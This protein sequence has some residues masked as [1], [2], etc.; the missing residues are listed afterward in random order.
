MNKLLITASLVATSLLST[1]N[2]QAK[3][4]TEQNVGFTTGAITG[5][6]VGGPIG[7]FVGAVAGVLLG[8]QVEKA[9][10]LETTEQQLELSMADKAQLQKE[11]SFSQSHL[12][13]E[14]ARLDEESQETAAWIT[15][16]LRLNLLFATNSAELSEL[17]QNSLASVASLLQRFPALKLRLDAHADSRGEENF[18][19]TLSEKRAS[20]VKQALENLGIAENRIQVFAHGEDPQHTNLKAGEMAKERRVSINF[21]GPESEGVAQN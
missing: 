11:L 2:L 9:N 16:T 6:A 20:Q 1:S 18:N 10:Q 8:E 13:Q 15:Q 19:L 5:A 12:E 14:L 17:D 7:F 4:S 21:F 3:S